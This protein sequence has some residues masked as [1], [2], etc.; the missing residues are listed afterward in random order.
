MRLLDSLQEVKTS[1][2]ADSLRVDNAALLMDKK[3]LLKKLDEFGFSDFPIEYPIQ[4]MQ[5]FLLNVDTICR[6]RGS[7]IG[8]QLYCS[9]LSLGEVSVLDADFYVRPSLIILDSIKQGYILADSKDE[10]FYICDDNSRINPE[11]R[12]TIIIQSKFFNGDFPKEESI[13]KEYLQSTLR[14]QLGFSPNLQI[15]FTFDPKSDFYYHKLL[16]PYFV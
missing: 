11:Q 1:I 13:I 15:N 7:K 5:Q 12:L 9:V 3:W 6:T 4:I 8:I 14:N 10:K 2:I 16:N